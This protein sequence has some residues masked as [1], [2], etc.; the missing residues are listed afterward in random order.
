MDL[1]KYFQELPNLPLEARIFL[2]SNISIVLFTVTLFIFTSSQLFQEFNNFILLLSLTLLSFGLYIGVILHFEQKRLELDRKRSSWLLGLLQ[3]GILSKVMV[4]P[5]NIWYL[6]TVT[7]RIDLTSFRASELGIE[8]VQIPDVET[9]PPDLELAERELTK[10]EERSSILLSI[11]VFIPIMFALLN[12]FRRTEIYLALLEG[13]VALIFGAS[14]LYYF[15]QMT[16]LSGWEK[17][18]SRLNL[19]KDDII[20]LGKRNLINKTDIFEKPR[21]LEIGMELNKLEGSPALET[22]ATIINIATSLPRE[23]RERFIDR[24][25]EDLKDLPKEEKLVD[26]RWKAFRARVIFMITTA[27]AIVGLISGIS[28]FIVPKLVFASLPIGSTPYIEFIIFTLSIT[29]SGLLARLW[30]QWKEV[31]NWVIVWSLEFWIFRYF[32]ILI[33]Q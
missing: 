32:A 33:L 7:N 30:F 1:D 11:V 22:L 29:L 6:A 23:L 2:I 3:R 19:L 8:K 16:N 14:L 5:S 4:S 21:S 31:I 24:T 20:V 25:L 9:F 17:T 10:V 27:V 28:S 12:M 13:Q 26:I 18:V 15:R